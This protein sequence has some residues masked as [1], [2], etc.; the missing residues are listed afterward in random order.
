MKFE[1]F[2]GFLLLAILTEDAQK[3]M[4]SVIAARPF[5]QT[6]IVQ[7]IKDPWEKKQLL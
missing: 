4:L 2:Q 1:V 7:N 5:F 6:R 3:S